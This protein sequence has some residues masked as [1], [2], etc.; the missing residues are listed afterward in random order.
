MN[1]QVSNES[2]VDEVLSLIRQA[3]GQLVS[4]NPVKTALEDFFVREEQPESA[5]ETVKVNGG[6]K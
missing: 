4:V 3:G 2:H 1:I 6:K 5:T